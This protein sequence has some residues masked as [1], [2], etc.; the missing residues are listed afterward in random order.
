MEQTI[1]VVTSQYPVRSETFVYREVQ[2]LRRSGCRVIVVSL[3]PPGE[4]VQDAQGPID[5][6]EFSL[7]GA[8]H[9]TSLAAAA[10][11]MFLHPI[12]SVRTLTR[13][14]VDALAPG[15]SVPLG[16]RLKLLPQALFALG[17]VRR[18]EGKSVGHI[19]CQ[20]AHAPTT[21]GMYA[22]LHR[23][24]PF[25]FVGHA[26]DLFQRRA[27]LRRKLQRAT[28]V[29]CI[30]GWHR[31]FYGAIEPAAVSRCRVI[32]C[33]V[34]TT[35]W[36]EGREA[37]S[38]DRGRNLLTVG[39]LVEKKG[40]DTLIRALA[41]LQQ[42]DG[43]GW[44]LQVVGDGPFRASWESLAAELGCATR[45]EWLGAKDNEEVRRLMGR[46]GV[47]VLPCRADS[48]GDR[49]GIP[50]VLMEAMASGLPAVAGDLPA[51]REL[52]EDGVT[53]R[54]VEG[55]SSDQLARVL[56]ELAEDAPLRRR[57]AQEGRR[58]VEAEFSLSENVQ[59]LKSAILGVA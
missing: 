32:R 17:L 24:V 3:Y 50:V 7:Y 8:E 30:S 15:E 31:E 25:S 10:V 11:E 1:L 48:Q 2:G 55:G 6:P 34:D 40:I 5:P 52:V 35:T 14:L 16:T 56:R 54:L 33:G 19:H 49:D 46:A 21:I 58:R 38:A 4:K 12:R 37:D 43:G 20:F 13:A 26:N 42:S 45:V 44:S 51:I 23:G 18:A 39:R 57:L 9:W 41:L 36:G 47:F 59:R 28:F 27:L 22:A 29:S 53:G